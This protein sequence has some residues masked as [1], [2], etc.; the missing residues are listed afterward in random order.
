MVKRIQYQSCGLVQGKTYSMIGPRLGTVSFDK[1][2]ILTEA[3]G[4]LARA[5]SSVFDT[6]EAQQAEMHVS[7]R[8]SCC[9]IYHDQVCCKTESSA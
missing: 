4:F 2:E 7:V 9:E 5:Y 8:A 6:I 1:Q 3:D